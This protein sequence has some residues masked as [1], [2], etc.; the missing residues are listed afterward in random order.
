MSCI[1][2][3]S[4]TQWHLRGVP[5]TSVSFSA[6]TLLWC[7]SSTRQGNAYGMRI[8]ADYACTVLPTQRQSEHKD[9]SVQA[10]AKAAMQGSSKGQLLQMRLQHTIPLSKQ[11]TRWLASQAKAAHGLKQLQASKQAN[12][13]ATKPSTRGSNSTK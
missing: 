1:H 3:V 7:G 10:I 12:T 11:R 13:Q 8:L 5:H 2:A 4:G 9:R 6:A